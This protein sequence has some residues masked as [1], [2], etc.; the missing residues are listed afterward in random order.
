M[1]RYIAVFAALAI[2]AGIVIW[3]RPR[4]PQPTAVT[5]EL[6][7]PPLTEAETLG[8]LVYDA[9]CATCH[10]QNGAGADGA[11]PPLVHK[12][13][14]PGHHGDYAFQMAV[15]NGV[16]SHHWSFGDMP[17][18]EGLTQADVKNIVSYVRALQRANGIQ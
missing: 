17:P 6:K 14:E 7:I 3:M 5:T 2:A 16:Q 12:I 13:Y 10:G 4:P 18:V 9:K 11:G 1:N 8:K 15:S